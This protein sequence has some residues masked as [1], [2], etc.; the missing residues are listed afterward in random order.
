M[1]APDRPAARGP[2]RRVLSDPIGLSAAL[3]LTAIVVACLGATLWA[4]YDP[5]ATDLTASLQGPSS[6]H[7]LGTDQLGRDVLSRL[8][9]GGQPS[10]LAAACV[11]AAALVVGVPVAMAAGYH[12]GW[13]DALVSRVVDLGMALPAMIIVL[14]VLALFGDQ[15]IFSYLALGLLLVPA[16]VRIVRSATVAVRGELFIDAAKVSRVPLPLLVA[17]HIFPRILGTVVVQASII[18]SI[19]LLFTTG[20]AYLGFGVTAPEPSWG[21]MVAEASSV[22]RQNPTML[23]ATG[24]LIGVTVLALGS[25]GEVVRDA[26]VERWAPAASSPGPRRPRTSG[27]ASRPVSPRAATGPAPRPRDDA[28]LAVGSMTVAYGPGEGTAVVD[29]VSFDVGPGEIVGLVG[30]S[31]CGKSTV[32]RA[33]L[34]LLRGSGRITGGSVGFA[35]EDLAAMS[36]RELRALRGTG[37]AFVSQ[38][39]MVALDPTRRV[40]DTVAEAVR[41]HTGCSR[42]QARARTEE[43][44]ARVRFADPARVC[45]LYPHEISGGMAQRVAIARALAGGPRLLVADEPTTALDVTV[46]LEILTL[47]RDLRDQTGLSILLVTHDWGV[48]ADLC[49]RAVVMYA[50]QVVET[51]PTDRLFT[52]PRH[53]YTAG[54]L[55]A[56]PSL[57][58]RGERLRTIPGSVP[59]P[60]DWPATCRF[61]DRCALAT[62]QC[63]ATPVPLAAVDAHA[64]RCLHADRVAAPRPT[65]PAR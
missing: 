57:A 9:H 50:G 33:V 28:V 21:T 19:G 25:L 53:P 31:G 26:L 59:P 30:E 14:L 37:I 45:G 39:P 62:D 44:F 16:L 4:P 6:A 56:N 5:L 15:L 47:L 12:G 3:V 7:L 63:R 52:A 32:A 18:A 46:Q 20:L 13:L 58:D 41:L 35:G 51:A 2:L 23:W 38:E 1:T 27:V 64:S 54:L 10:L 24:G 55:G 29:A 34:G 43:L 17:R 36:R 42:A 60:A 11:M 40:G 48:V 22:M 49:D 8:L 61:A 65:E